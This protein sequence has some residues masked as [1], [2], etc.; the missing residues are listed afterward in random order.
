HEFERL[1]LV[2]KNLGCF[3][4]RWFG[5]TRHYATLFDRHRT[6]RRDHALLPAPKHHLTNLRLKVRF[7]LHKLL[8]QMF[9]RKF[10]GYELVM[11]M[12]SSRRR[13]RLVGNSVVTG[14][15][16]K[17]IA[18]SLSFRTDRA[19]PVQIQ[20]KLEAMRMERAPPV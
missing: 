4:H 7:V 18:P 1:A 19:V 13:Q 2:P 5:Q 12:R 9:T 8:V 17:I 16:G 15:A 10:E 6:R 11:I 14:I 20:T 3:R